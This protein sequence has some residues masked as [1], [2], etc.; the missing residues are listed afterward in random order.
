MKTNDIALKTEPQI[1]K[2]V[3]YIDDDEY[4][5]DVVYQLLSHIGFEV[6]IANCGFQAI[7][8]LDA[9][10]CRF[11]IVIL[12]QQLPDING[13]DLS[14]ELLKIQSNIPIILC[15]GFCDL[16]INDEY[17]KMGIRKILAKPFKL[18]ELDK[19]IRKLVDDTN[20]YKS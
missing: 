8:L 18:L 7:K 1:A 13:L 16:E 10:P 11:D 14:Q 3:L 9:Q 6:V 17:R 20:M 2:C 4:V 12:D 15:T 19:I 5:N